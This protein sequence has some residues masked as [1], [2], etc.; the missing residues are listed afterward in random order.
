MARRTLITGGAGFI[1][2]HLA[3]RLLDAGDQV[4]ILDDLSNSAADAVATGA[5]FVRG[6]IRDTALLSSL[7]RGADCIFHLA[8]RVSVQDCIRHW[9]ASHEINL[10]GTISVLQAARAAGNVPVVHASSAA[11]YGNVEGACRE[12][13][14]PLPLSPYAADKLGGEHHARAMAAIHGLRSV[15]LRFFNVY[16]THQ[17]PG[18]SYAGVIAAFL[19]ARLAGRPY[20]IFGDGMQSRDFIHVSD[21]VS[22]LIRAREHVTGM[23][24][25]GH[26][27]F[28]L[29]TG[30]ATT[31]LDLA[32]LI[33]SLSDAPPSAR[34]HLPPQAGDI[35]M[36]L[37]CPEAARKRLGF[38]STVGMRAGLSVLWSALL[39]GQRAG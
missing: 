9:T 28:N 12:T 5:G 27:V 31:L 13:A 26:E 37:G 24:Q 32:G 33:D 2:R 36:S 4:V 8:A 30:Q 17:S 22:G 11:V 14:L 19:D 18:S 6:D 34:H 20:R 29:C 38:V 23:P 16:G 25:G 7:A 15:G 35:R 21:I 1:G 10:A 39:T 3:R